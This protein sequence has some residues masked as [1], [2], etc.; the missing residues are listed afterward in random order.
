MLY[1]L[2]LQSCTSIQVICTV[3]SDNLVIEIQLEQYN[4]LLKVV[5]SGKCKKYLVLKGFQ[6]YGYFL[7]IN[8]S[9]DEKIQFDL[10]L[11]MKGEYITN[12]VFFTNKKDLSM[13]SCYPYKSNVQH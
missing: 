10:T 11:D 6:R 8:L 4:I 12:N 3:S 2:F 1:F 5:T 9:E 13:I 7:F